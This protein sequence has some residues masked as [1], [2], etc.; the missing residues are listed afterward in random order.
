[1]EVELYQSLEEAYLISESQRKAG[2]LPRFKVPETYISL[3]M[4]ESWKPERPHKVW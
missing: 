4:K 2:N 1:M 3:R